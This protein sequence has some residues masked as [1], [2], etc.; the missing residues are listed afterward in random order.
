M[1]EAEFYSHIHEADTTGIG[2]RKT[3]QQHLQEV[4][5]FANRSVEQLPSYFSQSNGF[6]NLVT[7]SCLCHDFGKFTSYFQEYL[8]EGKKQGSRHHHGF[9]SAVFAAFQVSTASPQISPEID[10]YL[11]MISYLCVLHHHGHLGNL[12]NDVIRKSKLGPAGRNELDPGHLT[13]LRNAEAQIADVQGAV[14]EIGRVYENLF[15]DH[16]FQVHNFARGWIDALATMDRMRYFFEN[17]VEDESKIQAFIYLLLVYSILI[18]ADKKSAADL[19]VPTLRRHLPSRLVDHYREE[20]PK[21]DI[22]SKQGI[23]GIRNEIYSKVISAIETVDLDVCHIMTL[24]SPTGTGKTLSAL[25]AALKL[26]DRIEKEKGLHRGSS[27]LY[28]SPA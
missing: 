13:S 26:R 8:L 16:D 21:I 7:L 6:R 22:S 17:R 4:L 14:D 5:E 12:Q 27:T 25:S 24:T 20:C 15:K 18:D 1:D 11:P 2:R 10:P 23:N 3:L 19:L 28:L 9:I